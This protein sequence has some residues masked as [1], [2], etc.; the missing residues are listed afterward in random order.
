[1]RATRMNHNI[2]QLSFEH[3]EKTRRASEPAVNRTVPVEDAPRLKDQ[4]RA[5]HAALQRGP[6]YTNQLAAMA[7]QYNARIKELRDYLRPQGL[8]VDMTARGGD[9]NNRY[10]LRPFAGSHY[11]AEL[12]AKQQRS[13]SRGQNNGG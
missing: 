4:T 8:T 1:M 7:R 9:G 6:L 10:E 13:E 5:I 12:M 2:K 11:Q 3:L